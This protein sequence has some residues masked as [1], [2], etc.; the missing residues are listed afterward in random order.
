MWKK[1]KPIILQLM[2]S[3]AD[4]ETQKYQLSRH[5]FD[6]LKPVQ[7]MVVPFKIVVTSGVRTKMEKKSLPAEG[8]I[9]VLKNSNMAIE[10]LES[11]EF[12]FQLDREFVFH[13]SGERVT[14]EEE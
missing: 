1:Y 3:S 13:V 6:D 14:Q 2:K 10:R 12:T 9:T 4:G 5:E 8:L 7:N 11:C